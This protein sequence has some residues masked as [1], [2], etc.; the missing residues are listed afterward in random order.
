LEK[1]ARWAM[2]RQLIL[3][4]KA[5]NYLNFLYLDALKQVSPKTVT[6]FY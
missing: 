3:A 6:V 1:E 2:G 4:K 5:P